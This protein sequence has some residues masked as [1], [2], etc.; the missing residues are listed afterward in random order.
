MIGYLRR[1][2]RRRREREQADTEETFHYYGFDIPIH[3]ARMTGGGPETW[4][5]IGPGH[6]AQ[7]ER[8]APISPTH[9]ILEL[10]CGIGRDAIELTRLLSP[11]GRYIGV[12]IIRPSIDWARANISARFPHFEFHHF[13][14][15]SDVH[16][17]IGIHRASD[18]PLPS[19]SGCVDRIIAQSVFTHLFREDVTYYLGEFKRILKPDGLAFTTFFLLD[20]ETRELMA[21]QVKP[22]TVVPDLTFGYEYA[23]GVWINDAK[24]PEGA[25]AYHHDV[26]ESLIAESGLDL[27]ALHRGYWA[28][29][30]RD[31]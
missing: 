5:V 27:I 3:L 20:D 30:D 31:Q 8:Y 4:D 23:P 12:D 22:A 25:V 2:A 14:I 10:G 28:R 6:M 29:P 15:Y 7:Y 26:V 16:N 1:L 19:K 24:H 9:T 18:F 21:A 11:R 13:D 17:T